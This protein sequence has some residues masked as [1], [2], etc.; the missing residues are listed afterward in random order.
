ML[1]ALVHLE[2]AGTE[3]DYLIAV[4]NGIFWSH[5]NGG[6]WF[7]KV[8]VS[9]QE[10]KEKEPLKISV[11]ENGVVFPNNFVHKAREFGFDKTT[12][13][14]VMF[15]DGFVEDPKDPHKTLAGRSRVDFIA[16]E[17]QR[18]LEKEV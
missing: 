12:V 1:S 8:V 14:Q 2:N 15:E 3:W 18:F 11:A 16:N 10:N 13:G 17:I 7:D 9:F 4:E 5:I 6:Q